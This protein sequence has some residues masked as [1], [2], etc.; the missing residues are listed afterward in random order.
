M[1]EFPPPGQPP[2]HEAHFESLERQADAVRIGTWVFLASELL[3]FAALFALYA[4][5]RLH[6]PDAFHEGVH[7]MNIYIGS[8]N[9][10]I[11]LAS[12]FLSA[13]AVQVLESNTGNGRRVATWLLAAA[14][15]LGVIFLGL[16][17]WEWSMHL[18]EGMVPGGGTAFYDEHPVRGLTI[19]ASLYYAMTGLHALHLIVACV[20]LSVFVWLLKSGRVGHA[21]SHRL[22]AGVLYWHMVDAVWIFLWPMFYLAGK[23]H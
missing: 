20:I 4:G 2:A 13:L 22:E 21:N 14:V 16:K 18:H 1:S 15:S 5:Y 19:F 8:A 7:H 11:L 3:L 12:S 9:T 17:F 6:W 10:F 23:V